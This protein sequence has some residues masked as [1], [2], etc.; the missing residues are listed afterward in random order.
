VNSSPLSYVPTV[1]PYETIACAH[2]R[3]AASLPEGEPD[4]EDVVKPMF[5]DLLKRAQAAGAVD[6]GFYA[7]LRLGLAIGHDTGSLPPDRAAE[8]IATRLT[9]NRER[10]AQWVADAELVPET[11]LQ[12]TI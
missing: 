2:V 10:F 11:C 1:A 8:S 9:Q 12:Q 5:E 3:R 4:I 6:F 7:E